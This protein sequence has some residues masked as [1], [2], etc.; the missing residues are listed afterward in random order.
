MSKLQG[1]YPMNGTFELT[2]RCNLNCKMCLVRVDEKRICEMGLRERT[3]DE[4]IDMAKQAAEA[5][6][7]SLLLTGGEVLMRPDFCE[8][9]EAIAKIGFLL[10][11]YTNATMVTEKVMETFRRY[12]PHSIGVTMY[13]A[14]NETY[15]RLCGARDGYDRFL[16]GLE[17][18]ASLPS[19]LAV[20][21]TIVKDNLSDLPQM[22]AFVKERFGGEKTLTI[23]RMV[24][25][26]VRGG[27]ADPLS[28]RLSPED[29]V[30]LVHGG[31]VELN[32]RMK[33]GEI[34]YVT[35][36]SK[37]LRM[38][39]YSLPEEGQYLFSNCGAGKNSYTI[40]WSGRMF[41]CEIAGAGFTEPF[42][43]GFIKAWE[44]LPEQF[45]LSK[46][47]E[48]C[49]NCEYAAFCESCPAAR[50]SETG[51]WFGIPE[52]SCREAKALHGILKEMQILAQ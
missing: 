51:D 12:P 36:E 46:N 18:L 25:P 17:Q 38:R 11:V 48:K 44:R 5:G 10:T 21:T 3:A 1:R 42:G 9:Y 45:P 39:R 24:S 41:A 22:K 2:G 27:I 49:V 8:I 43:E 19:R 20:R 28:S 14:S 47:V 4:W 29:N 35:D 37:K 30:E 33:A 50:F 15:E 23:S 34:P 13:G 40:A 6:T 16:A 52:Y 31:I 32:R 26:T 7:F